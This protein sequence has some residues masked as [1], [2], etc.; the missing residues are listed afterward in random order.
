[1]QQFYCTRWQEGM[2][3]YVVCTK[4][5][6]KVNFLRRK[7][8][9]MEFLHKYWALPPE[10]NLVFTGQLVLLKSQSIPQLRWLQQV[11]SWFHVVLPRMSETMLCMLARISPLKAVLLS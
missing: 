7:L 2:E 5:L 3:E 6:K 1:M 9:T 8:L 10:K 11:F 4:F